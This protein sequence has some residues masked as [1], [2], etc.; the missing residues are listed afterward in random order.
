MLIASMIVKVMPD[1]AEEIA[2]FLE[3]LPNV[4]NYGVHKENN[5]IVVIEAHDEE[6][7]E[8]LAKYILDSYEDVLGV[9][10]TFVGSDEE[11][12]ELT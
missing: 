3:R 8:N 2:L 1:K 4:T 10:P 9:F 5:I 7:L 11:D 6:Q 12:T